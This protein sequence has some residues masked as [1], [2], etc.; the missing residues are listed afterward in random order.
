MISHRVGHVIE[1][2]AELLE[3]LLES[4]DHAA[5]DAVERLPVSEVPDGGCWFCCGVA[6]GIV[7]G[8]KA[9]SDCMKAVGG[10]SAEELG[11]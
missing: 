9:C 6:I 7:A 4:P 2:P 11:S 10:S 5:F 8:R 3:K 1:I